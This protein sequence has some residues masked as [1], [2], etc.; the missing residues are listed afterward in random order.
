MQEKRRVSGPFLAEA[1]THTCVAY[2]SLI[3][4]VSSSNYL[5][6]LG[7]RWPVW[8]QL[9]RKWQAAM[10]PNT[11]GAASHA[12][13]VVVR[14]SMELRSA[15]P[16]RCLDHGLYSHRCGEIC[17]H[18]FSLSISSLR[19]ESLPAVLAPLTAGLCGLEGLDPNTHLGVLPFAHLTQ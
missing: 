15:S 7:L 2:L 3:S 16:R 10:Q 17:C 9:A 13:G 8:Q 6:G 1:T 14:V 5:L 11:N 19:A 12:Y 18:S 4:F